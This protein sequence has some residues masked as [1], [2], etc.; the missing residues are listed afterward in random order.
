VVRRTGRKKIR[1][2]LPARNIETSPVKR[3]TIRR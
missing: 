2:S 1:A 3:L